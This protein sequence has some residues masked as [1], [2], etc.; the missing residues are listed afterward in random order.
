MV[1]EVLN[2]KV[3]CHSISTRYSGIIIVCWFHGLTH[4][5][6]S[7]WM[8][9]KLINC[10]TQQTSYPRNYVPMNHQNVHN[11]RTLAPS[12]ENDSTVCHWLCWLVLKSYCRT[13]F[14][15]IFQKFFEEFKIRVLHVYVLNTWFIFLNIW[16][17]KIFFSGSKWLCYC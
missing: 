6:M 14:Y 3:C 13:I 16:F 7:A 15:S 11:P 8:Y 10:V 17:C 5:F 1:D 4:Y 12:N 2:G 9:N